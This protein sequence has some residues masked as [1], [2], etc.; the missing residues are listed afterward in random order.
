[1]TL[2]LGKRA[3]WVACFLS[4]LIVA[5]L[6]QLDPFG[7]KTAASAQ[8]E[9][10]FLRMVGGPW[11]KSRARN[12]IVVVLINDAYLSEIGESWPMSYLAQDMLLTDILSHKPKAVFLDFLYR[13]RHG[14]EEDLS[15]Y[16]RTVRESG[17][18]RD[19]NSIPIYLPSL[20]R[21]IEGLNTCTG[22]AVP[23][24]P[25]AD[26]VVRDSVL[27][28]M[29]PASDE[30]AY[31][32]W[33]G[34][35]DRYPAYLAGNDSLQTPAF[36][37]YRHYC[38][39][40][41]RGLPA[42][43]G[44][45]ANDVSDFS[46]PMV[47]RWGTGVSEIHYAALAK[48]GVDCVRSTEINRWGYAVKQL[49]RAMGQ[50]LSSTRE[51]GFAERCTYTD[52]LNAT[53]FTGSS[54]E[55]HDFLKTMIRNRYVLVGAQVDGVSDYILSPVNGQLPGVYLFA[56]A[57][58][59]LMT[60][61]KG[62]FTQPDTWLVIVLEAITLFAI[63]MLSGY[64]H[65]RLRFSAGLGSVLLSVLVYKALIPLCVALSVASVM[66][67]LRMVPFDWL[68]VSALALIFV[69]AKPAEDDSPLNIDFCA[70]LFRIKN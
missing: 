37:L 42:C 40:E 63:L 16:A 59:N 12:E 29:R 47:I 35:G 6:A 14:S 65:S 25:S 51:R 41:G 45:Q 54:E 4:L 27:E 19:G 8:S 1:M 15:Q 18:D 5:A 61:G 57:L 43:G 50:A 52:T 55:L 7:F 66:W 30:R 64:L 21:D 13:H 60:M 33:V 11:Y 22:D 2:L 24:I 46:D 39:A 70:R 68:T 62:Y 28:V 58:D 67:S 38:H 56:M 36:A 9:A 26:I 44:T 53:W 20:V 23:P 17:L 34:C 31:I 69:S 48:G 3:G 49:L 10:I 32:G